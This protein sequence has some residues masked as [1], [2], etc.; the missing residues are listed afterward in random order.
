MLN[1]EYKC[2]LTKDTNH[3]CKVHIRRLFTYVVHEGRQHCLPAAAS[4]QINHLDLIV[5]KDVW[6]IVDPL[7]G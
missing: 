6:I 7:V 1:Q 2:Q 4:I 3:L 5:M